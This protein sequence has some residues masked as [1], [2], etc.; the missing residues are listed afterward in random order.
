MP[1]RY[2]D[3]KFPMWTGFMWTP[4]YNPHRQVSLDVLKQELRSLHSQIAEFY[5]GKD[6]AVLGHISI[7]DPYFGLLNLI[8]TLRLGIYHDALHF[9]DVIRLAEKFQGRK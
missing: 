4:R 3:G 2:R 8:L 6:E 5:T 7:Y 9:E 1:D